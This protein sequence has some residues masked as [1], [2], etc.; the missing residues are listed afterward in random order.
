MNSPLDHARALLARARDDLYVVRHRI[1]PDPQPCDVGGVG[2]A[3]A[4]RSAAGWCRTAT[5][6]NNMVSA[7]LFA[8]D[9]LDV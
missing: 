5:K 8:D 7:K 6:T 3:C 9:T 2:A 4:D 1:S